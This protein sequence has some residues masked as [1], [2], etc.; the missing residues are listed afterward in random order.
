VNTKITAELRA[1]TIDTTTA[2]VQ[3]KLGGIAIAQG[4]GLNETTFTLSTAEPKLLEVTIVE[5]D[6]TETKMTQEIRPSDVDILW[7]AQS[8][9]PP[10]YKGRALVAAGGKI[11]V[12]AVPHI[13]NAAPDTF[14]Y[15]WTQDGL[16]LGRQ[17]GFGKQ[18]LTTQMPPFG[19]STL[20]GVTVKNLDGEV[21]GANSVRINPQPVT[22]QLY[23]QKPLV[24]LW[25]DCSITLDRAP[26]VTVGL[27]ALPYYIDGSFIGKNIQYTWKSITGELKAD[28]KS[29]ATYTPT[30]KVDGKIEVEVRH[31]GKL[32]QGTSTQ[33]HMKKAE[34][35]NLFGI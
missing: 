19:D 13:N 17:S 5:R 24:G 7:E 23:Q 22:L 34:T 28:A 18:S 2:L 33:F 14:I 27:R 29:H 4:I 6:G 9:T 15:T 3:W 8:Y 25:T 32:L 12:A 20:I 31:A 35:K 30:G 26:E 16:T 10:L 21:V 1:P 11:V